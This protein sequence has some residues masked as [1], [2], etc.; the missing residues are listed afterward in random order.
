MTDPATPSPRRWQKKALRW[1]L[2]VLV[3]GAVGFFFARALIDN[4]DALA[5]ESLEFSWMWV[6]AAV[7]FAVAVPLTGVLWAR[8]VRVIAPDAR[9]TIAEAVAVQCASWLLKYIPGQVGSVV[10][11]IVW[12]GRKGISRTVVVISF[13]YENVFLQMASIIP[14]VAILFA[15]LGPEIFGENITLLLLPVLLVVPLGLMMYRPF[16]HRVV[17]VPVRRALK[18][19]L[20]ADYF[21]GSWRSLRFTVEFVGPRIVNAIGFLLICAAVTDLPPDLWLPFSAAYVLAGAVGILAF[22]VPSGLGVREAVI[23]LILSQYI[24]VAEAIII[25]LLAR[26]LSTVGDVLIALVYAGVRR[27]IPKEYRP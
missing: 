1:G 26:L 25:S 11:K 16:F 18:R 10:N 8:I 13:V 12:A 6:V 20:P 21:L 5:A 19:D 14:S 17:S 27:T 23:V 15:S 2:T 3:V 22:F 4:W 9:V 24:P 7:V